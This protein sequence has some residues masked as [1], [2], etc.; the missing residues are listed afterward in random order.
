[1]SKKK[2]NRLGI[3]E[4]N[5]NPKEFETRFGALVP[6]GGAYPRGGASVSQDH[7]LDKKELSALEKAR[8]YAKT[9]VVVPAKASP[10]RSN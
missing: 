5:I 10:N 7:R 6:W 3:P 2:K 9:R 8:E 4:E 1:M